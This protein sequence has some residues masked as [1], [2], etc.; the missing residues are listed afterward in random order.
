MRCIHARAGVTSVFRLKNWWWSAT[1]VTNL[2]IPRNQDQGSASE[3]NICVAAVIATA[4]IVVVTSSSSPSCSGMKNNNKKPDEI[5]HGMENEAQRERSQKVERTRAVA[6]AGNQLGFGHPPASAGGFADIGTDPKRVAA[7][8]IGERWIRRRRCWGEST[9]TAWRDRTGEVGDAYV[10]MGIPRGDRRRGGKLCQGGGGGVFI[11][12]RCWEEREA[13][14]V[15]DEEDEPASVRDRSDVVEAGERGMEEE[16]ARVSL[17]R[18]A[19][20][21]E[22]RT[23]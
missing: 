18:R 11:G 13:R 7:Q 16:E 9:G 1:K 6:L 2:R 10:E 21:R 4:S 3:F 12:G 22:P 19:V 15:Q 20:E 5:E 8:V 17:E 23:A 14:E